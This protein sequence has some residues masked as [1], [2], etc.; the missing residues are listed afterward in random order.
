MKEVAPQPDEAHL[1][2]A[3]IA[4]IQLNVNHLGKQVAINLGHNPERQHVSNEELKRHVDHVNS[5]L[6]ELKGSIE[7]LLAEK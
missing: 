1:V 7:R 3:Y 5:L 2:K 4:N 6:E